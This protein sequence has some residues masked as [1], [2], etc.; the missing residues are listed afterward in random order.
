M[1]GVLPQFLSHVAI[2][3]PN[4]LGDVAMA[5]PSLQTLVLARPETTFHV[6]GRPPFGEVVNLLSTP[7]LMHHECVHNNS[8]R[9]QLLRSINPEAV[10]MFT[11]SFRSAWIA[12]GL[13]HIRIGTRSEGRGWL[14]TH[15]IPRGT[16]RPRP[17]SELYADLVE[18][19]VGERPGRPQTLIS[20]PPKL[21]RSGI[22]L[23]PG[24]SRSNKRWPES[25][26]ISLGQKLQA[27]GHGITLLGAPDEQNRLLEMSKHIPQSQVICEAGLNPALS[28][29]QHAAVVVGND[30]GP[31]H[32][33][34]LFGTPCVTL[35]GPTD[36]RWT[37]T[38][39]NEH[40]LQAQP[41]A[42]KE[43]VANDQPAA[44]AMERIPVGDVLFAVRN[45][46]NQ[47]QR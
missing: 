27:T 33:A 19:A 14:L 18:V 3:A 7:R 24:A 5:L 20:E 4:W 40:T 47:S 34:T 37:P 23:V 8:Q 38:T 28:A 42:P 9:R 32:L 44:F 43:L 22:V 46:L 1:V 6:V 13:G 21:T 15:A 11:G 12:R 41:F 17:T 16:S 26:F 30:T 10:I 36:V 29:I 39:T 45:I 2:L 25:R 35:F 31:R